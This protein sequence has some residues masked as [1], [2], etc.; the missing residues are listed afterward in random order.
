MLISVRQPPLPT[1]RFGRSLCG[2][3]PASVLVGTVSTQLRH[4]QKALV[5]KGS[6]YTAEMPS[7]RI[8]EMLNGTKVANAGGGFSARH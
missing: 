3:G 1:V 2:I 7:P 8:R 5:E 6:K 4:S